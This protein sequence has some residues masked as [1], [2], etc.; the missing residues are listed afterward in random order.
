[1]PRDQP[2]AGW[3]LHHW[4]FLG[5][6]PLLPPW[7]SG[8]TLLSRWSWE[9]INKLVKYS[10]KRRARWLAGTAC[11]E[12]RAA[13]LLGSAKYCQLY[14]PR[15][16]PGGWI[17]VYYEDRAAHISSTQL[18][19]GSLQYRSRFVRACQYLHTALQFPDC[20]ACCQESKSCQLQRPEISSENENGWRWTCKV[21]TH[22]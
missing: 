6:N 15:T 18:G 19:L 21:D 20:L 13:H 9:S 2:S 14:Y 22:G 8:R 11:G 17:V 4:H 1:M 3:G 16:W 12:W 10:H 5:H 7:W